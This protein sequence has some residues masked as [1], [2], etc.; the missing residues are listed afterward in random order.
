SAT[1]ARASRTAGPGM[2]STSRRSSRCARSRASPTSSAAQARS[3]HSP[4]PPGG[5]MDSTTAT[6][7]RQRISLGPVE[8]WIVGLVAAGFVSG[9]VWF[10]SNLMERMDRQAAAASKTNE[11]LQSVV[12]QQ[13]VMNGQ[14]Q[15]L[16][17]QLADVPRLTREMA[18]TKV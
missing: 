11:T 16:T 8:R 15:T 7:G 18:E 9:G 17:T 14:V 3:R 10:G 1:G 13:A 5:P 2:R 12:T 6:D 4:R